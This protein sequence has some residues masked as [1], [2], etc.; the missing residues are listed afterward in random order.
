[1]RRLI[2]NNSLFKFSMWRSLD[3]TCCHSTLFYPVTLDGRRGTTDQFATNPFHLD[4]FL[5]ALVELAKSIPVHSLIFFLPTSS[6]VLPLFLL[7][8]TVP[9]MIVLARPED[10]EI[11]PNH[12]SFRFLTR[13]RS[14]SYSLMAAWIF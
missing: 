12:I 1:M 13:V 6:S 10:L 3:K 8:F 2:I 4:L 9:C 7:S 14:L 11:W 5:A